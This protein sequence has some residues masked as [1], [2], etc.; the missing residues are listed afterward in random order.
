MAVNPGDWPPAS[1][2]RVQ[3]AIMGGSDHS[4]ADLAVAR[5]MAASHP[6]LSI[7]NRHNRQFTERAAGWLARQ[8]VCRFLDLG[9]GVPLGREDGTWFPMM[10]E[11]ARSGG[12]TPSVVYVDN[13]PVAV[14]HTA[15]R[16]AGVT[17]VTVISADISRPADVLSREP[18]QALLGDG[19]P[20][21][22]ILASVLHCWPAR[23]AQAIVE[24]FKDALRPGSAL[25]ISAAHLGEAATADR[26]RLL[27]GL[28]YHNHSQDVVT[29]FFAGLHLVRGSV[30]SVEHWPL[31]GIED[32]RP[33]VILGDVAFKA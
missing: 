26:R 29:G 2:A 23:D 24:A 27:P 11:A 1:A 31:G 30:S 3:N 13:D 22:I 19:E 25:V 6:V 20:A 17:G 16:I 9:C 10:H 18:V 15:R 14:S 12:V 33:G 8:G 5:E 32:G 21:A 4:A 7:L 28:P